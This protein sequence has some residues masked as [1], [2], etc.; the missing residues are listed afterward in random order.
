MHFRAGIMREP[1]SL[2]SR[3]ST[4]ASRRTR[5]GTNRNSPPVRVVNSRG[6][7][8]KSLTF[9]TASAL[10]PDP[11]GTL[12]VEPARQ[13]R[14]ALHGQNLARQG[15]PTASRG[16][17]P[18]NQSLASCFGPTAAALTAGLREHMSFEPIQVHHIRPL[19]DSDGWLGEPLQIVAA[20]QESG[21]C[22]HENNKLSN[23]HEPRFDLAKRRC[24]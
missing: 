1:G 3:A 22:G 18:P 5:S 23:S 21:S 9:A 8:T 20:Q 13:G 7:R 14:K 11:N 10:G 4:S 12:L 2:A 19:A 16:A 15:L 24:S 17:R 6:L